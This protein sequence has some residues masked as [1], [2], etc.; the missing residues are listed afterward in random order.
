VGAALLRRLSPRLTLPTRI[1]ASVLSRDPEVGAAYAR[2]PLVSSKASA[3]WLYAVARAQRQVHAAAGSLRL[4][5][6]VMAS[7][8]DLLVDPEAARRFALEAPAESVEFV[9]WDGYFHEMLNDAGRE[10]VIAR[11]VR[12]VAD[13]QT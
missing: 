6:L 13:H 8:G 3:G 5:T 1:D 4:P 9:W 11:I 10:R 12:W 7:G 2:D